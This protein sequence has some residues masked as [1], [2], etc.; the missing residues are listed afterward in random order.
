TT[1]IFEF[2]GLITR[3]IAVA[4]DN[5]H[6]YDTSQRQLAELQELYAKVSR[7]EQLKTDMIR[8]AAHDLRNPIG[9]IMGYIAVIKMRLSSVIT[10]QDRDFMERIQRAAER[11]E[12]I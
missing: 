1:D 12:R 10:D 8:I 6:L 4:L 5:A 2:L 3:R 9:V 11:M 7:L